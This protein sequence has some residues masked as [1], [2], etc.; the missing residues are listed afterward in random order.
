MSY[1]ID[2]RILCEIHCKFKKLLVFYLQKSEE[3]KDSVFFKGIRSINNHTGKKLRGW[4]LESH[5]KMP[6]EVERN[7]SGHREQHSQ[8][9]EQQMFCCSLGQFSF[10]SCLPFP[11][12]PLLTLVDNVYNMFL[13]D[14]LMLISN[15]YLLT[16]DSKS[17][18]I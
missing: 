7:I 16:E 13:Y 14:I 9:T 18:S 3:W 4:L 17:E 2:F 12:P 6:R 8:R 10:L 11:S 15:I 5:S 1:C